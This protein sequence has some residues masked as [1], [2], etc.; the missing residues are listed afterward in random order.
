MV[1]HK[2]DLIAQV[3]CV[4]DSRQWHYKRREDKNLVISA[5]TF[6]AS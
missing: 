2:E 1:G 6:K 5:F 4:L 3:C